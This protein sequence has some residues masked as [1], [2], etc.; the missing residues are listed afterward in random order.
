M[1]RSR[2][3]HGRLVLA[4]LH[5]IRSSPDNGGRD[6]LRADG[7]DVRDGLCGAIVA[8]AVGGDG[9]GDENKRLSLADRVDNGCILLLSTTSIIRKRVVHED[10]LFAR[11]VVV[12]PRT[13]VGVACGTY[14][15]P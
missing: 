1:A 15:S 2:S 4:R 3:G 11:G 6:G 10:S 5:A 8:I 14:V 7:L 13:I 12:M 9:L